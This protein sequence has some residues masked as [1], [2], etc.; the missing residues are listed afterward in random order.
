MKEKLRTYHLISKKEDSLE[1][2]FAVAEVEQILE[3]R[4]KQVD[5]HGI[6]VTLL[7]VPSNKRNSDAASQSLVDFGFVFELRV[8][9]LDG[10]ELDGNL[11]ARDD[12]DAEVDI[13]E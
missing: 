5:D 11:F 6:V 12:V 4:T 9:S 13:T 7:T 1:R 2:K 10:L 3:R 8:F